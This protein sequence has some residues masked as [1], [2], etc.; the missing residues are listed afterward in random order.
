MLARVA[1]ELGRLIEAHRLAVEDGG[2]EHVRI[3]ALDPGRGVDE[4]REACGVAFRKAVFAEA[5]DLSEAVFGE[6]AIVSAANH[7]VDEFVAEEMD[8]AVVAEGRHRAA[9]AVRLVGRELGGLDGDLHRLFLEQRNAERPLQNLFEFVGGAVRGMR[10]RDSDGFSIPS[11]RADRD[12][13]CRPGSGRAAR[14]RPR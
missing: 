12:A 2:A 3:M 13:P 5:L 14:S 7:A 8:I 9:Q 11:R 6:S 10:E 4:Q 1:H